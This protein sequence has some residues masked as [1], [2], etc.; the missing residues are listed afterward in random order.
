LGDE[1]IIDPDA[2]FPSLA[3]DEVSLDADFLLDERRHT[4][5]ARLVVS[6]VTVADADALHRSFLPR[7]EYCEH[8]GA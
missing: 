8:E 5:S 6:N 3:F 2:E 1:L 7:K 4:G